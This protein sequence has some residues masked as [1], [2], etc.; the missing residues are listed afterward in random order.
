MSMESVY[1]VLTLSLT[2]TIEC[3]IPDLHG[4]VDKLVFLLLSLSI[5][6]CHPYWVMLLV[7]LSVCVL[8]LNGYD[9][10]CTGRHI[11]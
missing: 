1:S 8:C 9:V 10:R 7:L 2:L 11:H 3:L 6:I 4:G 5:D